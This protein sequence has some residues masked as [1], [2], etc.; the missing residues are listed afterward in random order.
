MA[1]LA[2]IDNDPPFTTL[3][4]LAKYPGFEVGVEDST[5]WIQVFKVICIEIIFVHYS[6][7]KN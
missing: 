1:T 2:V 7:S 5:V 6:S 4:E 3:E